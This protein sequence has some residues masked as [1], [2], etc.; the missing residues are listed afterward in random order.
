MKCSN[1][2]IEVVCKWELNKKEKETIISIMNG[3]KI[4]F[5]IEENYE[6]RC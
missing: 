4:D 6:R 1:S 3:F 5:T 2:H